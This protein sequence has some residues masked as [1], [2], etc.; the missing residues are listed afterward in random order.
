MPTT[1]IVSESRYSEADYG[2]GTDTDAAAAEI[3][4][5]ASPARVDRQA[6]KK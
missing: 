2:A 5:A 3:L 4:G 6:I 1:V